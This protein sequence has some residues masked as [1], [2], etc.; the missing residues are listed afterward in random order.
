MH[1]KFTDIGQFRNTIKAIKQ[2]AQF[3]RIDDEGLVVVDRYAQIPIITFTGSVKCHGTNAGV[4]MDKDDEIWF[5]SKNHN[6]TIE[7][8]NAGF[9]FFAESKTEIFRKMLLNIREKMSLT[10]ETIILYGEWCGG[11]IQNVDIAIRGLPKMFMIFAI[12]IVTADE[13]I[14]NYYL[15][16]SAVNYR[17]ADNQIY[18]I[19]DYQTFEL[20]IDF[21]DPSESQNKLV[22]ITNE[23]ERECPVGKAFGSIGIGEGV[24]WVGFH[25]GS[26]YVF[27]VKGPKHSSSKVKVT[28]PVDVEKVN[29]IKE[30][31]SYAVTEN[32][33]NQCIEQVFTVNGIEPE[34]KGTGNFLKW[35]AGDVAKEEMDTMVEN[36]L[37]P[38]DVMP[39]VKEHARKWFFAYL[40]KE[41]GL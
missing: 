9:A 34:K 20:D 31:T 39:Y 41:A 33:L 8:D 38:N 28:A 23:V 30:F 21:S 2:S 17:D 5:Q 12:K 25:K 3:V 26:R 29:S 6:V 16:P 4:A 13:E 19:Y 22:E 32:R 14:E 35:I 40:D 37:E 18:N 24:V 27:K 11:N 15:H 7:K 36:G 10:N 1:S